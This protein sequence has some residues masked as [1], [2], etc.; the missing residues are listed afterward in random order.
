MSR[1]LPCFVVCMLVLVP[2][3][4]SENLAVPQAPDGRTDPVTTREIEALLDLYEKSVNEAD[5]SL[6]LELWAQGDDISFVNP[7]QRLRSWEKLESF[8]QSVFQDSFSERELKRKNVSIQ[9]AGD[10]AWA[11]FDW[12]FKAL[13]TDGQLLETSGWE[14]QVYRLTD[15]GWRIAHIHFSAPPAAPQASE[16]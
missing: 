4:A 16:E 1:Q 15:R 12:D 2:G 3:C 11:V 9:T 8:W 5:T 7:L 14:T 10:V 13:S 6:L